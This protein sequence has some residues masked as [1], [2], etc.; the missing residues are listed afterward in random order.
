MK[1][2]I[3]RC[4]KCGE[5]KPLSEYHRNRRVKSG[6]TSS[7][8]ACRKAYNCAYNQ[9]A[10]VKEKHRERE[11]IRRQRADVKEQYYE[12]CQRADVKEQRLKNS[13][14][15]ESKKRMQDWGREYRQRPD[16]K[17]RIHKYRRTYS[18]TQA[19]RDSMRKRAL[20]AVKELSDN[21]I[22]SIIRQTSGRVLK[23]SDIPPDLVELKRQSIKLKRTINKIKEDEQD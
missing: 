17:E 16:V 23:F 14:K 10:D 7:C 12:Y 15:K 4:T 11:K 1:A 5:E 8:K 18:Q 19:Y 3:K 9:R 13:R 6:Y 20:Q 21:Y 2:D 22:K